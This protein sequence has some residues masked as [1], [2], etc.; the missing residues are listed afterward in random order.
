M[1]Q[2]RFDKNGPV[3]PAYGVIDQTTLGGS[4]GVALDRRSL[5]TF[6]MAAWLLG[7]LTVARLIG[8]YSSKVDL[9]YDEAQ[10]W[11]WS[12]QLA[13]GYFS[14]PPLLAWIISLSNA[15]CG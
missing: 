7:S 6:T 13:F 1:H 15:V 9:F 2:P 3:N 10:Y 8:L 4:S 14:K 12:R 5:T 11:D